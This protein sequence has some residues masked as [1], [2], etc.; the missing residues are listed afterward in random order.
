MCLSRAAIIDL[1]IS[2]DNTPIHREP[3]LPFATTVPGLTKYVFNAWLDLSAIPPGLHLLKVTLTDEM[4]H[5]RQRDH[6]VVI[7]EALLEV[8]N[9]ASDAVVE[10][11]R[12]DPRDVAAQL[13]ARPSVVRP[14]ARSIIDLPVRSI[15]VLR[16][17]QLGDVVISIPALRRLRV[18]FPVATDRGAR[19]RVQR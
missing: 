10:V 11:D 9:P 2:V 13:R 6:H 8:A 12:D 19:D 1:Q 14:P 18:L 7:A 4:G 15:L 16:T 5:V 3:V 17:D